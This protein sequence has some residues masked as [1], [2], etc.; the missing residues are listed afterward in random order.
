MYKETIEKIST[1]SIKKASLLKNSKRAYLVSSMFAGSFIGLGVIVSSTVGSLLTAGNSPFTKIAMGLAFCI[2]LTTVVFTGTELFTGN[3][4]VMIIGKLNKKI[5]LKDLVSV[6]L[7][8][9]LGNL[10][11]A[12]LL[13][14]I[15]VAT[16]L[17]DKGPLM[18]FFAKSA[19]LKA[20][21]PA[22][23]LFARAIL[24]NFIVC[25]AVLLCF[26]TD[27]DLTKIFLIAICLF[28][29]VVS[30]FEH[31]V[32]NMTS[33]SIALMAKSIHTISFLQALRAILIASIGNII[34]GAFILGFG[35]YNS[36][37]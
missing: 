29:F 16:G 24:C 32:A 19:L 10:L 25:L 36:R 18:D 17:V 37:A 8:S 27:D 5:S 20:S 9:W 23:A 13:S 7:A 1:A 28:G 26:R 11:G 2:A 31:S 21:I 12:I 30:G 35:I 34:G 15:F 33:F 6:W 22:S 3:N 4:F 14:F